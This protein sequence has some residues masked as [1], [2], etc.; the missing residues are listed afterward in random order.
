MRKIIPL[1]V[2]I[3]FSAP[4]TAYAQEQGPMILEQL[5]PSERVLVKL[6]W[7]EVYP[8]EVY[9]FKVSFHDPQTGEWLDNISKLNYNVYV[10]QH[11]HPVETYKHNLTRDGTGEFEVFFP[12]D[13]EGPAEV[14]V[15]L[16]LA[17]DHDA[18]VV[19]FN[20]S[21][22]FSVNV[23]PEF[24]TIA[25]MILAASIIPILLVSRN[26]LAFGPKT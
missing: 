2:M 19:R 15:E 10:T 9:K 16:R 21:V 18:R 26:R 4:L 17:T 1:L 14:T 25:A 13:A 23:V 8:D 12:Q 24:G 3:L 5:T 22:T 6:E 7:P 11:D 20:E